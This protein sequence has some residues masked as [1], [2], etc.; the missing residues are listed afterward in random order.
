MNFLDEEKKQSGGRTAIVLGG[1]I[2]NRWRH[3][4]AALP[5]PEG[6]VVIGDAFCGFNSVYGQGMS[7]AAMTA[8]ALDEQ[9]QRSGGD[10]SELAARFQ[11][12]VARVTKPVWQLATSADLA[13]PETEGG[14]KRLGPW[15]RLAYWYT[16]YE[17]QW[18]APG[19]H[20]WR[21]CR[22]RVDPGASN[23]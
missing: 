17:S 6:F 5:W 21:R 22:P 15:E 9:L 8:V 10:L 7:V 2:A 14:A 4:E 19:S 18:P 1:S 12:Q 16:G 13:Y 3:Y 20:G 11:A 23:M